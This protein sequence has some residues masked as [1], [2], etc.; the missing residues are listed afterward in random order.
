MEH[1]S[2]MQFVLQ[3]K[4]WRCD[5]LRARCA[6]RSSRESVLAHAAS[7]IFCISVAN[8]ARS[9]SSFC[10]P[11]SS[12]DRFCVSFFCFFVLPCRW[13]RFWCSLS[14]FFSDSR[15]SGLAGLAL[16]FGFLVGR[17]L[18]ATGWSFSPAGSFSICS[19]CGFRGRSWRLTSSAG[20]AAAA[21][22]PERVRQTYLVSPVIFQLL[23]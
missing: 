17:G 2:I 1:T 13:R 22:G 16:G 7:I 12:F 20:Y 9:W 21:S 10:L 3:R 14:F 6:V 8:H 18:A 4:A 19:F 5:D 23:V 15:R 11:C